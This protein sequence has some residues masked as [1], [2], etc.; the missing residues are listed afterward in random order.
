MG[1]LQTKCFNSC[2]DSDSLLKGGVSGTEE[3]LTRGCNV[4]TKVPNTTAVGARTI[5]GVPAMQEVLG[6]STEA[7]ERH[8]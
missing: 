2:G 4:L 3:L 6:N 8:G 7:G 1:D 5:C